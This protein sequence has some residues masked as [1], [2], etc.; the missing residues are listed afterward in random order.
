M[1]DLATSSPKAESWSNGY[2]NPPITLNFQA[3]RR[4][5]NCCK[6]SAGKRKSRE[7]QW[8]HLRE[9]LTAEYSSIEAGSHRS[10]SASESV[11]SRDATC[12]SLE[13]TFRTARTLVALRN[14]A[15]RRI[16]GRRYLSVAIKSKGFHRQFFYRRQPR[17]GLHVLG[18]SAG[19][20]APPIGSG[21]AAWCGQASCRLTTTVNLN[22][23]G[24]AGAD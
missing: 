15:A 4:I 24:S 21:F 18:V 10:D 1:R 8:E 20:V 13:R 11:D 5:H 6:T 22:Y 3:K 17:A 7:V 12:N 19:V 16:D 23:S 2:W 9:T 14:T